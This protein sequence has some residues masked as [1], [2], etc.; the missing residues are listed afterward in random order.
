MQTQSKQS[1]LDLMTGTPAD[2][3]AMDDDAQSSG[4]QTVRAPRTRGAASTATK[5]KYP[6]R[7]EIRSTNQEVLDLVRSDFEGVIAEDL[8]QR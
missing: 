2:L 8:S 6:V 4:A 7:V 5:K 1:M 3:S